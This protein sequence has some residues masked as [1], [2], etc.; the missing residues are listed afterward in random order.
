MRAD[1]KLTAFIELESAIR[2]EYQSPHGMSASIEDIALKILAALK[3]EHERAPTLLKCR[4]YQKI[5]A[6]VAKQHRLAT[7]DI[8]QADRY[9]KSNH[10]IIGVQRQDEF[11][12][13]PSAEGNNFLATRQKTLKDE[14]KS[15]LKGR[16]VWYAIIISL[17]GVIVALLGPRSC[18]R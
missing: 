16:Q 9:L 6:E 11:A 5:L 10:L 7:D 14:K 2:A 13:L 8:S 15:K 12:A 18:S 4:P 3:A 17:L 1:E